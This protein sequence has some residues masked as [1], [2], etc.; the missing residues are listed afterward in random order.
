MEPGPSVS[1]VSTSD[2]TRL[3]WLEGQPMHTRPHELVLHGRTGNNVPGPCL[4]PA[5]DMCV[6][7]PAYRA[8][9]V[10]WIAVEIAAMA[11]AGT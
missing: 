7:C 1:I 2:L 5:R 10:R 9:C 6:G 8:E 3:A 4:H 11:E